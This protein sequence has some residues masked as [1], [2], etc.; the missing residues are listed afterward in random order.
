LPQN[1]GDSSVEY[2]YAKIADDIRGMDDEDNTFLNIV[3]SHTH[4]VNSGVCNHFFAVYWS[5]IPDK[6]FY[7]SYKTCVTKAEREGYNFYFKPEIIEKVMKT[8]RHDTIENEELKSMLETDGYLTVYHGHCKK[9]MRNSN[10]WMINK[11]IAHK[12]GRRNALFNKSAEY[13]IV[14]GRIKLEDIIVNKVFFEGKLAES[15][16]SLYYKKM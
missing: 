10:S 11:D 16:K 4:Q 12:F 14:T 7:E 13:Y 5:M 8:N 6:Y 15:K 3:I 9:T 2:D 1:E